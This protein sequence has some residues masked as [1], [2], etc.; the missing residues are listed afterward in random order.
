[1][2]G[3][4]D[5]CNLPDP[6]SHGRTVWRPLMPEGAYCIGTAKEEAGV[7]VLP[8]VTAEPIP[9]PPA[10]P[11]EPTLLDLPTEPPDETRLLRASDEGR[12]VQAA[13]EAALP[14]TT[15]ID[16]E[17]VQSYPAGTL[18]ADDAQFRR[19]SKPPGRRP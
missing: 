5:S 10:M 6:W 7:S 13:A 15:F 18:F 14:D 16:V 8:G 1:M 12:I 9:A 19:L 4:G 3:P 11:S 2:Y 17:R